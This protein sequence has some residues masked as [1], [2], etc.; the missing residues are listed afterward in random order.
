MTEELLIKARDKLKYLPCT[1]IYVCSSQ[2]AEISI[3]LKKIQGMRL[4]GTVEQWQQMTENG[5]KHALFNLPSDQ[6][7][8]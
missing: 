3:P 5:K 6:Q 1:S 7:E 4:L 8:F 2:Y